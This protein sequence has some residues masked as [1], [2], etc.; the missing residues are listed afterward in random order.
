MGKHEKNTKFNKKN[1]MMDLIFLLGV[2]LVIISFY[3]A[4]AI[5]G[6]K[7]KSVSENRPLAKIPQFSFK[8]FFSGDY[9]TN[10]ENS[11]IDQMVFSEKIKT[12]MTSKKAQTVNDSQKFL[13]SAFH[14]GEE[15]TKQE[16]AQNQ[17]TQETP[18][19][20]VRN[21][22]YIPISNGVYHYGN[23]EYMVFKYRNL[24]KNK[25]K[26]KKWAD[27]Y[28]KYFSDMDSYFYLVNISKGINFNTVDETENEFLTYIKSVLNFKGETG[29]KISSYEQFKDY[30]YQTDH[31]WNYKG[32]YQGYCDIINMIYPEDE[33]IKPTGT[34]TYDVYY[35]GSN[36]RTTSIYTN[37][38]KFTVYEFDLKKYNTKIN[39]SYAR[40]DNHYL[41]ENGTYST[42]KGYNHYGVYY[43]GDYAEVIYEFDQPEK[44][45]LLIIAPSYSNANNNLI[46]SH[47]NKTYVI[48]LRHYYNTFKEVFNPTEYCKKNNITKVLVMI[49]IDHMT[50]GNFDLEE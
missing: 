11:L 16:V 10:L 30:F 28:N 4:L 3:V 42:E 44:E 45:N 48:D 38:E 1:A 46:A 17:D 39:G 26:L 2:F 47:F 35:Y 19:K 9:Q 5:R 21:I 20:E 36:A 6:Q 41:Y 12:N 13:M 8:E 32:S 18:K 31:H 27:Q 7:Q 29:L 14:Y 49:S 25:E 37:K 22:K 15:D 40:Y 43:G 23:S 24:E 33:L 34:K 50:N